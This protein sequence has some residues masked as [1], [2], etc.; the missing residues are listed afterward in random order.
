MDPRIYSQ[1][2]QIEGTHWWFTGRRRIIAAA[3]GR[4]GTRPR[5]VLDVGC[6]A[7]TNLELLATLY[8]ASAFVGIDIER[9]P[10]TYCRSDRA[11][12]VLQADVRH[13]PFAAAAFDL[14]TALDTLEHVEDDVAVLE[15]LFRACRP[16]GTLLLTVP[17]FPFLWGN[18]DDLG[19][20]YRRYRRPDLVERVTRAGFSVRLLRFMNYLLFPPIAA[21]RVASRIGASRRAP[22]TDDVRSDFDVVKSGPLNT[23]LARLFSLEAHLLNLA[24][25]FG[26]SLLCAAVRDRP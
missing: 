15:E 1:L 8:P 25:P 2:R 11:A 20:H 21:V 5:S 26:V 13:L 12:P 3:L 4:L 18:V 16:G 10:L 7:G 9:E 24:P 22:G 23:F 19:H 14:I 17:A 6:G